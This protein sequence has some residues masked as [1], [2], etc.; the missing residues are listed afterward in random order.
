MP[1]IT[2]NYHKH[3][4]SQFC[5]ICWTKK[6][7]LGNITDLHK[8]WYHDIFNE[9]FVD[10]GP[11]F[12]AKICDTCRKRL[13]RASN[14]TG[15][16]PDL[17]E[18]TIEAKKLIRNRRLMEQHVTRSA[19]H[20]DKDFD[21]LFCQ[22][23]NLSHK[24]IIKNKRDSITGCFMKA[25]KD[26]V[27]TEKVI[28]EDHSGEAFSQ[29]RS[30]KGRFLPYDGTIPEPEFKKRDNSKKN[31]FRICGDPLPNGGKCVL[32]RGRGL[33][34]H[35]CSAYQNSLY[36]V[37]QIETSGSEHHVLA[38]LYRDME[39]NLKNA[40]MS[41]TDIVLRSVGAP[42]K[43]TRSSCKVKKSLT[44][45]GLIAL[46]KI[47][48]YN[49]TQIKKL[50]SDIRKAG[51]SV[52]FYTDFEKEITR[53]T[54]FT[55]DVFNVDRYVSKTESFYATK[56]V[57][58]P[59]SYTQKQWDSHRH[60][61]NVIYDEENDTL[62]PNVSLKDVTVTDG[63]V[64]CWKYTSIGYIKHMEEFIK[65]V[66]K[67]R[68]IGENVDNSQICLKFTFDGGANSIK[69]SFQ[70]HLL[71]DLQNE[72]T[73]K[74]KP[75]VSNSLQTLL[76]S[77]WANV[78]E[79]PE[80]LKMFLE[81][82]SFQDL[83]DSSY[84]MYFVGDLKVITSAFG[85]TTG[86]SKYPCVFCKW[87]AIWPKG[88][89]RSVHFKD[90]YEKRDLETMKKCLDAVSKGAAAKDNLSHARSPVLD[91]LMQDP[92]IVVPCELHMLSGV[93]NSVFEHI[94]KISTEDAKRWENAA[95]VFRKGY[96]GGSFTGGQCRSLLNC[97]DILK[98]DYTDIWQFLEIFSRIVSLTF[99]NGKVDPEDYSKLDKLFEFLK[100]SL[101]QT[102][103]N[104]I[105]KLH[106]LCY[107]TI[108]WIKSEGL[109]LGTVSEQDGESLHHFF[110]RYDLYNSSHANAE[111]LPLIAWNSP[112]MGCYDPLP[113]R[114]P[115][116]EE[117]DSE[118][119]EDL[120]SDEVM[121]QYY[122]AFG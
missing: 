74:S 57:W 53:R 87:Q 10:L 39:K 31:Y 66:R 81:L 30:G 45:K 84:I 79:S 23:D 85:L 116:N 17:F 114:K 108:D 118:D 109:L 69:L 119:Q 88:T 75:Y 22:D 68:N 34:D 72:N 51:G 106:W 33:N 71:S 40:G 55:K 35:R 111:I 29:P 73:P 16:K 76:I 46:A 8:K 100:K 63:K 59:H 101:E 67:L 110:K 115:K 50:V 54:Q 60:E 90:S 58:L 48:Y 11:H 9:D 77:S 43:I 80:A 32:P 24:N 99:R 4:I 12:P 41:T 95:S 107:H 70:L 7:S 38:K 82:S 21:C 122:V 28:H 37:E 93:I 44:L 36:L 19:D 96:Q 97:R 91:I 86:N 27:L 98:K 65:E 47:R 14:N 105:H 52:P 103:L 2:D 13:S 117:S 1:K 20:L 89:E 104:M 61:Q 42:L 5:R 15:S 64:K 113:M 121:T 49:K 120:L 26:N 3:K 56:N 102:Q 83:Y 92:K 25:P 18:K 78:E 62:I 112:R 94:K 6:N